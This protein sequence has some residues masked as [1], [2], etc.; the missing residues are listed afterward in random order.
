MK[1]FLV[2]LFITLFIFACNSLTD[3]K[4]PISES[5]DITTSS[6]TN[7]MFEDE[8]LEAKST[9]QTKERNENVT[10]P[11]IEQSKIMKEGDILI[12]VEKLTEAKLSLDSIVKQNLGYYEKEIFKNSMYTQ[13]YDLKIR[14]PSANFDV[15][16]KSLEEGIGT[17][18]DKN[19]NAKDVTEEYVDLEIRLDN[20]RAYSDRYKK[21]LNKATTIK[22]MIAIQEKIRHIEKQVDSNLGRMK[23]LSNRVQF[24]TLSVILTQVP[25]EIIA[26]TPPTFM[27]NIINA[28][29]NG[30]SGL[31]FFIVVVA[32][33]WPIVIGIFL[34]LLIRKKRHWFKMKSKVIS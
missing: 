2:L 20:N 34:I 1:K 11:L 16:I 10:N 13:N 22:E 32:N 26:T 25:K 7:P 31:L 23:Y 30:Y 33:F 24:S 15:V 19:I 14:M 18:L 8:Y 6:E 3:L 4:R 12:E 27:D 28:F 29:Q 21:M 17:I 5:S 9:P